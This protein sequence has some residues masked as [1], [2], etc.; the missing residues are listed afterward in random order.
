MIYMPGG[1]SL[2]NN[3]IFNLVLMLAGLSS[4]SIPFPLHSRLSPPSLFP[5][6]S[7]S[8]LYVSVPP[9]PFPP[10]ASFSSSFSFPFF[11][12]FLFF[13]RTYPAPCRRPDKSEI[14]T[15]S[16]NKFLYRRPSSPCTFHI[17]ANLVI[18]S[19]G[20]KVKRKK[21]ECLSFKN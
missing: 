7:L 6:V 11:Y 12:S 19:G 15:A 2:V 5:L 14:S 4:T 9:S 18:K 10:G 20:I 3:S 1:R 16:V 8:L 17:R 21:G 13:I